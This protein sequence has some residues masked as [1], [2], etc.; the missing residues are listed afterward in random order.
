[1]SFHSQCIYKAPPCSRGYNIPQNII[2]P[3]SSS[4]NNEQETKSSKSKYI[5]PLGPLNGVANDI[6]KIYLPVIQK[7]PFYKSEGYSS[8]TGGHNNNNRRISTPSSVMT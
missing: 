2:K 4:S 7:Q 5:T 8:R 3:Y 6:K 1:L